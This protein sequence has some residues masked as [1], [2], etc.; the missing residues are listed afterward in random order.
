MGDFSND[1]DLTSSKITF[2]RDVIGEE[3]FEEEMVPSVEE[4]DSSGHESDPSEYMT[5]S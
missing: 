3:I 5:S 4:W 1:E 2:D